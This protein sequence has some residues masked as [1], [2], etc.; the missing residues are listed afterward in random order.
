MSKHVV[1]SQNPQMMYARF[2]NPQAAQAAASWYLQLCEH[3]GRHALKGE[4]IARVMALKPTLTLH[5]ERVT[6]NHLE[7]E[8]SRWFETVQFSH[9]DDPTEA[10]QIYGSTIRPIK[11]DLRQEDK[12]GIQLLV[13]QR[14]DCLELQKGLSQLVESLRDGIYNKSS[15]AELRMSQRTKKV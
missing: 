11:N 12:E 9:Y 6:F 15:D 10:R 13:A 5:G 2:D 1:E 8:L 3:M 14:R 4:I 7:A